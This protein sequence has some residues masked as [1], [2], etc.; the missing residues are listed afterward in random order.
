[1]DIEVNKPSLYRLIYRYVNK[2][3]DYVSGEVTLTPQSLTD[4]EQNGEVIF[5]STD[6]PSFSTVGLSGLLSPFVLNPGR[7]VVSL[8]VPESVFL[9][10]CPCCLLLTMIIPDGEGLGFNYLVNFKTYDK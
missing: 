5:M 6:E 8:K 4:V 10:S 7:W 1:M 9:V 2:N 3:D